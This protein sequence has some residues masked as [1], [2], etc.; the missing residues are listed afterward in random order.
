MPCSKEEVFQQLRQE[1][2]S[3]KRER[4]NLRTLLGKM[5]EIKQKEWQRHID[6]CAVDHGDMTPEDFFSTHGG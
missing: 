2:D 4:L 5:H 1:H 3:N 6:S